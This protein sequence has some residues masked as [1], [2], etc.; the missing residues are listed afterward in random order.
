MRDNLSGF[1]SGAVSSAVFL[2]F[3][4]AFRGGL[5]VSAAVG[6]VSY[7]IC[8]FLIFRKKEVLMV[9]DGVT[10]EDVGE[11]LAEG[12]QKLDA[13]RAAAQNISDRDVRA[14]LENIVSVAS[15][16]YAD[17]QKDPRNIRQARRFISYYMETTGYIVKRYIEISANRDFLTAGDAALG[18][19]SGSLDSL[20]ALFTKLKG[21]LMEDDLLDLDT[22]IKVLEQTIKSEGI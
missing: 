5:L 15:S 1:L 14:K 12:A 8:T 18:R 7:V 17:I 4:L 3:L 22:E 10:K 13:L 6:V 16:I 20:Y 21:R 2:V 11:I 9:A 19:I